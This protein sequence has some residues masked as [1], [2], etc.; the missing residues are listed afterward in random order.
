MPG[1]WFRRRREVPRDAG[2]GERAGGLFDGGNNCAQAVLQATTGTED[3]SLIDAAKA[4]SGG[5]GDSGCLCGALAGGVMALGLAGQPKKAGRLM[6][7]FR[8]GHPAT[9]CKVLSRP[10]KWNSRDHLAN[11]RRITA[12]TAE[13][14]DRLLRE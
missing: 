3:K 10:F 8:E 13:I 14:V 5:I 9:C 2:A 12:E 6:E 1:R 4:F 11:C 7:L